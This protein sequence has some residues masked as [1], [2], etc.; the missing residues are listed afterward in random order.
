MS[1]ITGCSDARRAY[2]Y[3]QAY[4]LGAAKV[5]CRLD[6]ALRRHPAKRQKWVAS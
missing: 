6:K 5:I 1:D 2:Q 4:A 3:L